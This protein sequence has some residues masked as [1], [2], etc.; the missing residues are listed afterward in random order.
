MSPEQRSLHE[1]KEMVS[2]L[3]GIL[4]GAQTVTIK[5]EDGKTPQRGVDYLTPQELEVLKLQIGQLVIDYVV[6]RIRQPIDGKTPIPGV[7]FPTVEQIMQFAEAAIEKIKKE[8]LNR[9]QLANDVAEMIKNKKGIVK[10]D[11][12][13]NVPKVESLVSEAIEEQAEK[14]RKEVVKKEAIDWRYIK[15]KPDFEAILSQITGGGGSILRIQDEGSTVSEHVTTLNF[16]GAGVTTSYGG[17]GIIQITIAGGTGN[18]A[19]NE[20]PTGTQNGVNDTFTLANAPSPAASLQLY[21]NG[22]LLAAGGE[23]YTLSGATITY[24]N[25]KIPIST[26]IIRAWYQYA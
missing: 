17:N 26:D 24:V 20:T 3:Q 8:K 22:Q 9:N 11:N 14:L 1:V 23:D 19:H 6:P 15:N 2:A 18:F 13:G 16:L 21:M 10:W 4:T 12:I 5:G 25:A 7:D